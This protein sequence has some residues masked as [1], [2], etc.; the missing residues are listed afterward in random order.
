MRA[1]LLGFV[2]DCLYLNPNIRIQKLIN[3]YSIPC[4]KPIPKILPEHTLNSL[5]ILTPHES[6]SHLHHII[7][8]Y[9]CIT[10][11]PLQLQNRILNMLINRLPP[12]RTNRSKNKI[13]SNNIRRI[14]PFLKATTNPPFNGKMDYSS[15]KPSYRS[16][17]F[18][19][20]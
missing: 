2:C 18:I 16:L 3:Q 12:T 4:R 11:I 5:K 20:S 17:G 9:A 1:L 6:N 10:Q 8:S 7:Q 14:S 15:K 13:P 19:L